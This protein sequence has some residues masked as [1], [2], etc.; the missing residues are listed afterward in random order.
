M[1]SYIYSDLNRLLEPN[2]YMYSKYIGR[3]FLEIYEKNRNKMINHY[4]L[5][6]LSK[7]I[8][9]KDFYILEKLKKS[10]NSFIKNHNL[11]FELISFSKEEIKL[12]ENLEKTES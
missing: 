11:S 4:E 6:N 2:T 9:K 3:E 7:R 1:K 12:S 8:D 10:I 5:K